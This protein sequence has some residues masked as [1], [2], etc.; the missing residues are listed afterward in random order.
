MGSRFPFVV[1]QCLIDSAMSFFKNI[2]KK[3]PKLLIV[4]GN[5]G[6][7]K[8]F[9]VKELMHSIYTIQKDVTMI[10]IDLSND[11]F[12]ITLFAE[13]LIYCAWNEHSF[14]FNYPLNVLK[15]CTFPAFLKSSGLKKSAINKLVK[16]ISS[17]LE[18]IPSFGKP[19]KELFPRNLFKKNSHDPTPDI[20][21]TLYKY[22]DYIANKTKTYIAIDNYQFLPKYTKTLFESHISRLKKEINFIFINRTILDIDNFNLAST[23]TKSSLLISLSQFNIDEIIELV[24]KVIHC[25]HEEAMFVANRCYEKTLGNLKEMELFLN[26][27]K[28]PTTRKSIYDITETICYFPYIKKYLVTISSMFPAGMKKKYII[29]LLKSILNGNENDVIEDSIRDLVKIGYIVLNSSNGQLL[30]PAHEKIITSTK[31]GLT[32]EEFLQIRDDIL[33]AMEELFNTNIAPNDYSYILHCFVG[34]FSI[35]QY[36]TKLDYV[37]RLID[38]QYNNN[39]YQYIILIY[40]AYKEIITILPD[41]SVTQLLD[42]FQKTSEIYL[43]IEAIRIIEDTTYAKTSDYLLYKVKY[44][45]QSYHFKEALKVCTQ[46]DNNKLETI[47]YRLNIYQHLCYDKEAKEIIY[48]L[49]PTNDESYFVILRNSAH[50]FSYEK[51]IINLKSVY[52]YFRQNNFLF[53]RATALNNL[54]LVYLWNH[55][56]PEAERNLSNSI[57][58]FNQINSNEIFEPL[59][60][61]AAL[62]TINRKYDIA[63]EYIE[64]AIDSYPKSL[65]LDQLMLS[66]NQIIINIALKELDILMA[67]SEIEKMY[68][69]VT[70]I[71]DPWMQFCIGYNLVSI[72]SCLVTNKTIQISSYFLTRLNARKE[73]GNELVIK[74]PINDG[75][76]QFLFILSP[77]WRY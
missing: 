71:Q 50:Y 61:M 53:G 11:D 45:T 67:K 58:L 56:Y 54:G 35:N 12:T 49:P 72:E 6:T 63:K 25:N 65:I 24:K 46:L 75:L 14:E 68:E 21:I 9:L 13:Y 18:L 37:I 48:N 36:K 34:I 19:L 15:G 51:A 1:R 70:K 60:N 32:D 22:L 41:I 73:T 20:M 2:E 38:I 42:S 62:Y 26:A 64:R 57:E 74:L 69:C 59:C 30:K 77:H 55:S 43:G 66:N 8:T 3:Q 4:E 39:M 47:L 28:E 23:F 7:G 16:T 44:L 27:Y 29:E 17:T 5:S 33:I 52:N 76:I 31:K 10:Y 40:K